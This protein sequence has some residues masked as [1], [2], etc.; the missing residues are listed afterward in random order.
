MTLGAYGRVNVSRLP[1]RKVLMP[2]GRKARERF[3]LDRFLG[4][5]G[6]SP[7]ARTE[8]E[9]PDFILELQG[10]KVGVEVTEIFI[11][12]SAQTLSL[13][14]NENTTDRI[15]SRTR[16]VYH[17]STRPPVFVSVTFYDAQVSQYLQRDE[18]AAALARLIGTLMMGTDGSLHWRNDY[19]DSQLGSIAFISI[20][21]GPPAGDGRW[22]VARGMGSTTST[23]R[24]GTGCCQEELEVREL[25]A[26]GL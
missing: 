20:V 23:V 14:A 11:E 1:P 25:Q 13:R 7:S 3:F 4:I 2:R 18:T 22:S 21:P 10:R 6:L 5:A 9:S 12:P 26:A 16:E 19:S 17:Q 24:P 8:G 15:V